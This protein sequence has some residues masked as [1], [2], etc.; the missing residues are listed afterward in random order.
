MLK[1]WQVSPLPNI[2]I[3]RGDRVLDP[4]KR[5]GV[6][7]HAQ[8]RD[9]VGSERHLPHKGPSQKGWPGDRDSC[10][11]GGAVGG[12]SPLPS[13]WQGT[14]CQAPPGAGGQAP[15]SPPRSWNPPSS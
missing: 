1:G 3:S 10:Q 7:T 5:K 4:P 2:R 14:P 9:K 15:A 8:K 12:H 11:L 6:L 13:S